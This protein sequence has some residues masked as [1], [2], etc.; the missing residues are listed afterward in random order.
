MN[1]EFLI[2]VEILGKRYPL[3]IPRQD[4]E[5]MRKAAKLVEKK[6]D[7][8]VAKYDV[9]DLENTG[10]ELIALVAFDLAYR[11]LKT[12]GEADLLP[13]VERIKELNG[14]LSEYLKADKDL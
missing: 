12:G 13:F 5:I 7:L 1:D 9:K 4:E 14:E 3:R 11:S 8:Y 6:Y 10:R 2:Q